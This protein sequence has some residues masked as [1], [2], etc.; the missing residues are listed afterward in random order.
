MSTTSYDISISAD[1]I[2]AGDGIYDHRTGENEEGK[3]TISGS[4]RD[5]AAILGGSQEKAEEIYEAIEDAITDMDSPEDGEITV[6]GITYGW[7][8]TESWH[9]FPALRTFTPSSM[10]S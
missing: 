2:W 1:N 6:D 7:T 8:L 10:N 5:C 4:I 3:A 9:P